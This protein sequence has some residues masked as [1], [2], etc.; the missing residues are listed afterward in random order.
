M[1][2]YRETQ[3][4]VTSTIFLRTANIE[5]GSDDF[6]A[7]T[8]GAW[9]SC[10]RWPA[11]DRTGDVYPKVRSRTDGLGA[12]ISPAGRGSPT[13]SER[14]TAGED[15]RSGAYEQRCDPWTDPQ[16]GGAIRSEEHT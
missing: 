1:R 16:R 10:F 13:A 6:A 4:G 11:W 2:L 3:G 7:A 5:D 9:D 15:D 14:T 8:A 12:E